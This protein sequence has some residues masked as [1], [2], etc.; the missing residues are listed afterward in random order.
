MAELEM[1][2]SKLRG[3]RPVKTTREVLPIAEIREGVVVLKDGG[4]RAVLAVAST[5]FVLK[6]ADEQMAIIN[7]WQ[8]FLN[9][10]SFP[11]QIVMQSRRVDITSYLDRLHQRV[12]S[13]TNELL[14][15]Q[16]TEYIQ[17]IEKLVEFA[18]IMSKTFLIVVPYHTDVVRTGFWQKFFGG[19]SKVLS[20]KHAAYGQGREELERR[21]GHIVTGLQPL[22]LQAIRLSTE[23]L[24]E[25][26]YQSYN[27]GVAP[28]IPAGEFS[29]LEIAVPENSA[30]GTVPQ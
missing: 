3:K 17:Y 12:Q 22:G 1:Q 5:N 8:G 7:T 21:V 11:L 14:R 13:Q 29:A 19:S 16:T 6:S 25:L 9:S 2:S 18:S 26:Y 24:V 15:M 27:L 28:N 23:E 4:L 30:N 10:L 20:E